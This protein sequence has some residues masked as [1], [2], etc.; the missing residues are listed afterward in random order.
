MR[1]VLLPE[2]AI[3]EAKI[4]KKLKFMGERL[5]SILEC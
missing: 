4:R 5:I 1:Q 3:Q 2:S